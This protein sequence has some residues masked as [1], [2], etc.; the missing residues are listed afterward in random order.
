MEALNERKN[1]LLSKI[2]EEYIATAKPVSS[3]MVVEKYDID[4]SSAT[5]RNDMQELEELG[6]IA[7]PHTSAG[8]IPTE[9]GYRYYIAHFMNTQQVLQQK[10]RL[11]LDQLAGA[12]KHHDPEQ[13]L[14]TLAKGIA[15]LST[16]TVLVSFSPSSFYYTG[17]S[18][19]FHKPEFNNVEV[20][21]SLSE[22][23][24]HFDEAMQH[25]TQQVVAQQITICVGE[26]NP[27]STDCSAL[28]AAH[29]K[30]AIVILG[31]MRMNYQANYQLLKYAQTLLIN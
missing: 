10:L 18:N 3:K 30:G 14:K 6:Y 12:A 7:Q 21:Y 28:I 20:M 16:E 24:D 9:L 22:L 2:I 11:A 4:R 26:D 17:I 15:E 1:S 25:I 19:M 31:P 13:Y 23:V 27:I 5:I 29:G 8:R